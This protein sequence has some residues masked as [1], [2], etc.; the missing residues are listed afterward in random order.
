MLAAMAVWRDWLV[1]SRKSAAT[2]EAYVWEVRALARASPE[3]GP[4]DWT[5]E[6]LLAYLARRTEAGGGE[7][8]ARRGVVGGG[9]RGGGAPRDARPGDP[10]AD[11]G[12]VH[13]GER[14]VP[15]GRAPAELGEAAL[16]GDREGRGQGGARLLPL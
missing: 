1:V 12:L 7:G 4:A 5:T 11:P 3:L 8:A 6:R 2:V 14:A 15:A 9:G 16:H 13:P 10:A